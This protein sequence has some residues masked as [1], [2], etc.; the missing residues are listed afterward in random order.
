MSLVLAVPPGHRWKCTAPQMKIRLNLPL[1]SSIGAFPPQKP[2]MNVRSISPQMLIFASGGLRNGVDIAKCIALGASLG[3][4]ARP[5]LK[6]AA[7][8]LEHT[9]QTI[10]TIQRQIQVCMFA[11][12]AANLSSLHVEKISSTLIHHTSYAQSINSF[13][14]FTQLLNLSCRLPLIEQMGPDLA[15]LPQYVGLPYGLG[16]AGC[17]T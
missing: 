2:F 3:G 4:M 17:W 8:S 1:P 11:S 9:I 10:Q 13:T 14:L 7:I 12:G 15:E 5:F 6:A 16:R